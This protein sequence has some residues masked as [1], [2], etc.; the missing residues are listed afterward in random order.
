MDIIT[1]RFYF[2]AW[3][4]VIISLYT[5]VYSCLSTICR[6]FAGHK[7]RWNGAQKH[8]AKFAYAL[9][10]IAAS[11]VFSCFCDTDIMLY[12]CHVSPIGLAGMA[13]QPE[14]RH[15]MAKEKRPSV[16]FVGNWPADWHPGAV[17]TRMLAAALERQ[18]VLRPYLAVGTEECP[19]IQGVFLPYTAQNGQTYPSCAAWINQSDVAFAVLCYAP[20]NY[21]KNGGEEQLV[22]LAQQLEKPFL[23]LCH[24]VALQP[25]AIQLKRLQQLCGQSCAVVATSKSCKRILQSTYNVHSE[26]IHHIPQGVTPHGTQRHRLLKLWDGFEDNEVVLTLGYLSPG[27]GVE[28]AI[29]AAAELYLTRPSLRYLVVGPTHPLLKEKNGEEYR[30]RLMAQVG[31]LGLGEV[32]RFFDCRPTRSEVAHYMQM[33]DVCLLPHLYREQTSNSF[34]TQTAGYGKAVVSTPFLFAQEVLDD[35]RGILARFGDAASLKE[36]LA[37]ILESPDQKRRMENE[38]TRYGKTLAWPKVCAQYSRLLYTLAENSYQPA[39]VAAVV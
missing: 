36:G 20:D 27:L 6:T 26:K 2:K 19:H 35:H 4:F 23:L 30:S 29:Q 14:T 33:C 39:S 15:K 1:P 32:V 12:F 22:L 5:S 18:G 31:K 37:R 7:R 16:A 21:G 11:I 3:C 25:D 9:F 17:Q 34:L 13:G 28:Y 38:M 8:C 24:G 10:L